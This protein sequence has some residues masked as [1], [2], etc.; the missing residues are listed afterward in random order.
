M[1]RREAIKSV[2]LLMGSA[3]SLSTL[4]VFQSGCNPSP[5]K[6]SGVFSPE[7]KKL[8]DD[9]ADI[10][11]PETT[12]PGAREAQVG[13]V[14][15]TILEDCYKPEDQNVVIN[16][17]NELDKVSYEQFQTSFQ[18]VTL[19]DKTKLIEEL[20]EKAYT[21]NNE[22]RTDIHN[23]YKIIKELTLLGYFTSEAGVTQA[24][25]YNMVPGRFDGCVDLK[26]GQK[27]WA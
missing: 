15:A 20:D 3:L 16:S 26:P 9:I 13:R 22:E 18:K 6:L 23:G 2:A 25:N 24:L 5:E 11:I 10:I 17:L 1:K 27:A 4:T 7:H 14:I 19:I 8:F 12:S 21:L